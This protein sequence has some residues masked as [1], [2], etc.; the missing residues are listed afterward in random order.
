MQNFR[1]QLEG[2]LVQVAR[3]GKV[4][5]CHVEGWFWV[6]DA[7]I[8]CWNASVGRLH[9]HSMP[10]AAVF[11]ARMHKPYHRPGRTYFLPCSII[12]P[13]LTN[14]GASVVMAVKHIIVNG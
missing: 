7:S 1:E 2:F 14:G 13:Q 3:L 10:K 4:S 11:G 9:G 5:V 8:A 12:P 6:G